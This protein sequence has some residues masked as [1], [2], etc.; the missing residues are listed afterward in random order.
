MSMHRCVALAQEQPP[1]LPSNEAAP[2]VY[3]EMQLPVTKTVFLSQQDYFLKAIARTAGVNPQDVTI[4]SATEVNQARRLVSLVVVTAIRSR[5]A[6]AVEQALTLTT[7]NAALEE[8][9]L[10]SATTMQKKTQKA[11]LSSQV[12]Q[13]ALAENS[14]GQQ[15]SSIDI[16]LLIAALAASVGVLFLCIF[17]AW[18]FRRK[19]RESI[20]RRIFECEGC[21]EAGLQGCSSVSSSSRSSASS[22]S[23]G[24]SR[25][26][27]K[28]LNNGSGK[29]QKS[30]HHTKY[31]TTH[32]FASD[33]CQRHA[34]CRRSIH[35]STSA[36]TRMRV[37]ATQ[38]MHSRLFNL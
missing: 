3:I 36:C 32:D 27:C 33:S 12:D 29:R 8:A 1:P 13:K 26:G 11:A 31:S 23:L 5:D 30:Q 28:P 16:R 20:S 14:T 2:S 4:V 6:Q 18:M 25:P 10:P 17:G 19:R 35:V 21:E 24:K 9:G 38:C 7:V 22:T 37:H 34:G 15:P